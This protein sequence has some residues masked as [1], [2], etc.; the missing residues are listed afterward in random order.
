MFFIKQCYSIK[1]IIKKPFHN[2][3]SSLDLWI[4]SNALI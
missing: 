4:I 2:Y 1:A 3:N